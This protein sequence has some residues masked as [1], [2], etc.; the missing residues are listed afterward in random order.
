M[1][2]GS[3]WLSRALSWVGRYSVPPAVREGA[4]APAGARH[5]A[6]GGQ[7]LPPGAVTLEPQL[8]RETALRRTELVRGHAERIS[9]RGELLVIR[10]QMR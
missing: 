7:P 2:S 9:K 1:R 10:S 3:P 5:G 4:G 8:Y 6:C